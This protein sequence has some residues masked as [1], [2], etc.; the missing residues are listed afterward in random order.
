MLIGWTMPGVIGCGR[1]AWLNSRSA[2]G[3]RPK[4]GCVLRDAVALADQAAKPR[5]APV[6]LD[7]GGDS[8]FESLDSSQESFRLAGGGVGLARLLAPP[9]LTAQACLEKHGGEESGQG[10]EKVIHGQ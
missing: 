6:A 8:A 10:G 4:R 1:K 3:G 5:G 7:L 2:R 9:A